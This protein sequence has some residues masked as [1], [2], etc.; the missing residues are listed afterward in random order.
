VTE[1]TDRKKEAG[2]VM[3]TSEPTTYLKKYNDKQNY[4]NYYVC[5]VN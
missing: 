4:F 1:A 5:S 2:P 3:D